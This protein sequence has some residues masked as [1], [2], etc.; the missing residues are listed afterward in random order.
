MRVEVLESESAFV[1]IAEAWRRLELLSPEILPYQ[2][3]AWTRAWWAHLRERGP[4][5]RDRLSLRV[6]REAGEVVAV[7]PMMVTEM[8]GLGPVRA[9]CL[10]FIGADPNITEVRGLL[11]LP[12]EEDAVYASLAEHFAS[13]RDHDWLVWSGIPE[14]GQAPLASR[15]LRLVQDRSSFFIDLPA[16]WE[17]LRQGLSR[18]MKEALRKS[19]NAPKR[20]GVELE[21][22]VVAA[23]A[24][25]PGAL[26]ALLALH[27]HRASR[28]DTVEHP[29]VFASAPARRFLETACALLA[30]QG[31][32]HVFLLKHDGRPVAAR[33]AFVLG[34]V[35]HFYYSG[36][37]GAY[38]K[39][40]AMTACMSRALQWAIGRG[41]AQANLS[42]GRDA[43]KLRWMPREVRYREA[44]FESPGLRGAVA[45]SSVRSLRHLAL[46]WRKWGLGEL[47]LRRR[48]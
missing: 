29:D 26:D 11:C 6:V 15:R 38:A 4:W 3:L 25:L 47:A 30:E 41:L 7:A 28:D 43:S 23:P 1:E 13:S 31:A 34:R 18:N 21:F 17:K 12:G 32:T 48:S 42:T 39:Y 46:V 16:S 22:E 10:Q 37:L 19:V 2:T 20:D 8:P 44:L 9:R 24:M 35:L 45:H 40:S 33:L 5:M 14:K 27:A 36:Y